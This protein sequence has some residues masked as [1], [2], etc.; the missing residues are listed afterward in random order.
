M[1]ETTPRVSTAPGAVGAAPHDGN[2]YVFEEE[3]S[4]TSVSCGGAS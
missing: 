4:P 2:A 3:P 1:S